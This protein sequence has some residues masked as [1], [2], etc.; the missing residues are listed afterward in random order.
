MDIVSA[1]NVMTAT[2]PIAWLHQGFALKT[3]EAYLLS[4]FG[5]GGGASTIKWKHKADAADVAQRLAVLGTLKASLPGSWDDKGSW[6]DIAK[7]GYKML[8]GTFY[9]TNAVRALAA[10]AGI[11]LTG[12]PAGAAGASQIADLCIAARVPI[13]SPHYL[14]EYV[15]A[16]GKVVGGALIGGLPFEGVDLTSES[17]ML[18]EGAPGALTHT[19][20]PPPNMASLMADL[21]AMKAALS[22]LHLTTPTA[23]TPA[24]G[25]FEASFERML[26][27]LHDSKTAA[28]AK[29]AQP[30]ATKVKTGW[31]KVVDDTTQGLVNGDFVNVAKLSQGNKHR[32]EQESRATTDSHK[33]SLGGGP[34]GVALLFSGPRDDSTTVTTKHDGVLWS[35]INAFFRLFSIMASLPEDKFPRAKL[36]DFLSLWLEIWD[37]PSGT[38]LEKAHAAVAFYRE[39]HES[40]GKGTWLATFNNNARFSINNLPPRI[41]PNYITQCSSCGGCGE[42]SGQHDQKRPPKA[43]DGGGRGKGKGR[44]GGGG[45][46]GPSPCFSM[47][48]PT[49]GK[50]QMS[51]CRWSHSP[52][53]SCG[54]A[55]GSAADCV[56]FDAVKV[57]KEYGSLLDGRGRGSDRAK[58]RRHN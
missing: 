53:P 19:V 34:G 16:V 44:S 30:A 28:E 33:V 42:H 46:A 58:R 12:A 4:P 57:T 32:L 48:D 2:S 5:F 55:C 50:C 24:P 8:L 47:L 25:H 31:P 56:R 23:P 41:A 20:P 35:L 9:S 7:S 45:G 22:S 13:A 52:C 1:R 37:S 15:R 40:L 6:S 18:E 27:L 14:A 17:K 10:A 11:D 36:S 38:R 26:A 43:P 21:A 51:G 29:E 39:Y 49:I 54:G 3:K